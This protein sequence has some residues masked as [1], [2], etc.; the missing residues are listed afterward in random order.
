M[1]RA[2][3][4]GIEH[5]KD[6]GVKQIITASVFIKPRTTFLPDYYTSKTDKWIIFP[7]EVRETAEVLVRKFKQEDKSKEEIKTILK[8]LRLPEYF[9]D[10]YLA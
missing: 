3:E 7:Y 2:S 10:Q 8:S 5:L 9:F 4:S 6:L 1:G